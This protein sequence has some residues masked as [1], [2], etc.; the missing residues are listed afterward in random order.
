MSTAKGHA[1]HIGVNTVDSNHYQGLPSLSGC[2]NDAKSLENISRRLAFN[3]VVSLTDQTATSKNLIA[4]LSKSA[5][6]LEA[7]DTLWITYSGHG[8]KKPDL[9]GDESDNWDETWCLYDREMI[10]DEL[11][12]LYAKF[13]AGVKIFII[14]DSC[15]SGTVARAVM[16]DGEEKASSPS[17]DQFD[18]EAFKAKHRAKSRMAPWKVCVDTYIKN[19]ALYDPLLKTPSIHSGDIRAHVILF[20]SCQD[21]Q[22]SIEFGDNGYFTTMV[23]NTFASLHQSATYKDAYDAIK[24]TDLGNS[25][26][27]NLYQYGNAAYNFLGDL[28]LSINGQPA[29]FNIGKSGKEDDRQIEASE[30]IIHDDDPSNGKPTAVPKRKGTGGT[31]WDQAYS[32][33]LGLK[34]Q[35]KDVFVEPNIKSNYLFKNGAKSADTNEYL[36]SWPKPNIGS[37]TEFL[38][39]LDDEHSELSKA[40]DAV[41]K[42]LNGQTDKVIRIGHIDTGYRNHVSKPKFLAVELGRNF[43]KGQPT[44]D[45][46][47]KFDTGFPAEQDG[48]GCGT[49]AILA[50]NS[51]NTGDAYTPYRGYVGAIPF[52]EVVPLRICETVYNLFNANDV[53]D[54][55][56]YAVDCGCEVITMSMAGYPTKKVADAVNYAYDRGVVLVTAA[57]NNWY[58]GIQRASP[59]SVL[60]PARF[61]RVIAATG[62]CHD[63]FPYDNEAPRSNQAKLRSPGG[64]VMQGNWGPEKVMGTALASYTPNLPWATTDTQYRFLKNGGGTSSSTPQI[65][66]AAALWIV[67]H[68]ESLTEHGLEGNYKKVE[69]VRKALFSTASKTYPFYKKYYGNGILRAHRALE[70]F[71][72]TPEEIGNLQET[73]K[74]RV[75]F[76]GILPFIGQWF[77]SKSNG[78]PDDAK[79]FEDTILFEMLGTELIQLIHTDPSLIDYAAQIDF[80]NGDDLEFLEEPE[81]R[82][83]FLTKIYQ[84]PYASNYLKQLVGAELNRA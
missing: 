50:G 11:F 48:H 27:A 6:E 62:A 10:D 69:A 77:R 54:A 9:N 36:R 55:I 37:P 5:G 78:E 33:H 71:K 66:A 64:E 17:S 8:G 72:F 57:G 30:L 73:K 39:H 2:V 80:E 84:S 1:V 82:H 63:H 32:K 44:D 21:N 13:K 18:W 14:S 19:K 56:R 16:D 79:G 34:Q 23:L 70:A 45:T 38:W 67:Y 28:V 60:Y 20:A 12:G 3:S 51:I 15:H 43:I 31:I 4:T 65:A 29:D 25:Q 47:D 35:G 74:A 7:G 59:K 75:S 58:K 40:A 42:K 81:G 41:H 46:E 53:A 61:A 83:A 22:E 52:A 26:N 24:L 49:L 76:T 68:R